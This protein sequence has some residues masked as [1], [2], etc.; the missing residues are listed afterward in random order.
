MNYNKQKMLD[1]TIIFPQPDPDAPQFDYPN[2]SV[3][4]KLFSKTLPA[5][6]V[7]TLQKKSEAMI[8]KLAYGAP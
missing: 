8:K 6:L 3:I 5:K 1:M 7:E 4:I 2:S